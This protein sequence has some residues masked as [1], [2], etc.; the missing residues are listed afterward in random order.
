M[1]SGKK[2][3]FKNCKEINKKGN[4]D[5]EKIFII[6]LFQLQIKVIVK[7]AGQKLIVK[8]IK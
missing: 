4:V 2:L 7:E 8:I 6:Y 5:K 1:L 3:Y